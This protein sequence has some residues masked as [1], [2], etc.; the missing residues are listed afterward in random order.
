VTERVDVVV[1]GL[2]PGGEAAAGSLAQAGLS[3]VAV[4]G[5]L[6]GGE[7]P[8]WGCVPSKTMIRAGNALAEGRRVPGLAG[9]ASVVADWAPVAARVRAATRDWDDTVPV[10]RL[11]SHGAR[12][13]RGWGRLE[14]PGRVVVGDRDFEATTAVLL[15]P[16]TA[17]RVP[18]I[19]GLAETP[20]WTN[21]DAIEVDHL[22]RSLAVLG[23]GAIGL[24]LGQL[25]SRFGTEVTVIE[26]A[27]RLVALEEPESSALITAVLE[28]EGVRVLTSSSAAAV[29]YRDGHFGVEL[30]G[31]EPVRAEQ[32]LVATGRQTDL[33]GLGVASIGL[34]D[35]ARTIPVDGRLR[36]VP[37]VWAI[38]DA[39]GK[40]AFTHVS[41]YQSAIA[42]DDIL[43][44]EP[45]EADYKA[46][47]RVTFTD[48]EIGSVGLTEAAARADGIDVRTGQV[49]LVDSTRGWI[50][51]PGGD[52]LIKVV[53]D[54]GR[55]VLVGATS[56]GPMGGEVLGLLA[57]AVHAEV[58]TVRLRQMIYAYPTFHRAIETAL[59]DLGS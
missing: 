16:G 25:F 35:Q 50:H 19:P 44:R 54:A 15:N 4:D 2:G 49:D 40:G 10:E 48:P 23:G 12:F 46:L 57:L 33:A 59:A 18:P 9:Q 3:V 34:D 55:G 47:P 5:R 11:E 29:T 58:P 53:E 24:E 26:G 28:R 7:C 39:T 52:G 22:P 43:G 42:V 45:V 1:V 27:P 30:E 32:L 36:V 21:R 38:G 8:F 56:I 41:M 51:G 37:G 13:V 31:A 14:G 20:Y 17:P 6:C